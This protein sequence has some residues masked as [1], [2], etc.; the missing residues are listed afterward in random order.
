MSLYDLIVK[1]DKFPNSIQE[2]TYQLIKQKPRKDDHQI[3]EPK[4]I[5]YFVINWCDMK[6]YDK[7]CKMIQFVDISQTVMYDKAVQQKNFSSELNATV[8]HELRG[9]IGSISQNLSAQEVQISELKAYKEELFSITLHLSG[10]KLQVSSIKSQAHGFIK[11]KRIF[12]KMD[13]SLAQIS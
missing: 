6:F 9:P 2:E 3:Q 4:E 5:K 8:S 10:E 7:D 11:M 13:D 12:K 1:I